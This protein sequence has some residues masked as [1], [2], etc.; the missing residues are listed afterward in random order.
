MNKNLMSQEY[1]CFWG[2]EL[3]NYS[4]SKIPIINYML[5]ENDVICI[6]SKPGAGKS[7]LAKQLMFHLTT[8]TPF[9]DT[10]E[11]SKP[12]NVLYIQ[13]EGDRAETIERIQAMKRG[14]ILDDDRWAHINQDG[15][16]INTNNGIGKLINMAEKPGMDFDVIIIDP[17]YTTVKGTLSSDEVATDWVRNCRK[18]KGHFGASVI[19]L[20]HDAKDIFH[21]GKE[22]SRGDDNIFG[23]VYWSAFFNHNFKLKDRGGVHYLQRGK[24]RSGKIVDCLEMKLLE[25]KPL[26]FINVDADM[27]ATTV[28]VRQMLLLGDKLTAK[29][30]QRKL[31]MSLATAY[32]ALNKLMGNKIVKKTEDDGESYYAL[33]YGG[34]KD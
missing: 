32:R 12:R 10:Y 18:L 4:D 9:L 11:V 33:A 7:I 30:I 27:D 28:K 29:V 21:E 13:T 23:S 6:S 8:A 34:K 17:L 22:V 5:Y 15:I 3:Y 24:Q 31:K 2:D 16:I 26:M 25:P 19:V 20:H 1:G 14:L